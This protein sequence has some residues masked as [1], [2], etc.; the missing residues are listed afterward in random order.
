MEKPIYNRIPHMMDVEG[1]VV[2]RLLPV[3]IAFSDPGFERVN[4]SCQNLLHRSCLDKMRE[5]R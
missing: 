1:T 2:V 4:L 5:E 3:F